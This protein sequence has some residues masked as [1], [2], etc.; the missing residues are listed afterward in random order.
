MHRFSETWKHHGDSDY[1]ESFKKSIT[2]II[3]KHNLPQK[4]LEVVE[5]IT[6]IDGNFKQKLSVL[7]DF[8]R[9]FSEAIYGIEELK[10]II[11]YLDPEVKEKVN[12]DISL[13][14]EFNYYTGFILEGNIPNIP[15]GAVLL[16]LN[17]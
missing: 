11:S 16:T 6:S 12:F 7:E 5:F 9:G 17:N 13:V 4:A 2:D 8:F 15:V 14:R 1:Q 10:E 3:K